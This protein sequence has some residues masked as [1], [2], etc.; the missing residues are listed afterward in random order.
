MKNG[1]LIHYGL[2]LL[3]LLEISPVHISLHRIH[4]ISYR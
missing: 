3:L 2:L 1:L 4:A